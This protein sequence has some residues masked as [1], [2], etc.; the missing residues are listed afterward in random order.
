MERNDKHD[1][2]RE[3]AVK[4]H[5]EE[6]AVGQRFEFG[7]NWARF[8]SVLNSERIVEAE[9]SL[10]TMLG[11]ANLEGRSFLDVGSGS[12]LFSLAARR[13]GARV[14]SFDYDPQSVACTKE[15]KRRYFDDDAQWAIE[16]G[17]VLDKDYLTSLGKFDI[18]YSWGVLH[19]TGAMWQA[20]ENVQVPL[21]RRGYLFI[22]IYNDQGSRSKGWRK[23]K[24]FYCSGNLG[25]ML[26]LALF[27]PYFILGGLTV[28]IL[29]RQNPIARYTAYAKSR[30]MSRVH[31]WIDWLGG[32]PFEV[33][34]PEEIVHFY[35]G[36]GFILEKLKT[37]GGR[38]GC[39]EYVLRKSTE[40]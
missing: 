12:G 29:K 7:K 9:R 16:E 38:L 3:D 11:V 1:L 13:L 21:K 10:K 33:A 20:L 35:R 15:L 28:D 34:K 26:V 2:E 32:Y 25:R 24:Q 30:G 23:V 19:H 37:C 18:V 39:N 8:L 5:A 17:S 22:S 36:K 27:I 14:H 6:V 4:E 31:D 40:D